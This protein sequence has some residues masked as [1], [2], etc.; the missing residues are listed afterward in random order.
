MASAD[1]E[2]GL[3][4]IIEGIHQCEKKNHAYLIHTSSAALLVD[5]DVSLGE[6]DLAIYDDIRDFDYITNLPD[7]RPYR[8]TDAVVLEAPAGNTEDRRRVRTAIIAPATVYGPGKGPGN[9]RSYQIP[10]YARIVLKNKQ[11]FTLGEGKNY[12]T[13]VHVDNLARA[14]L[15]LVEKVFRYKEVQD[16]E[17]NDENYTAGYY[18]ANDGEHVSLLSSS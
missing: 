15:L 9:K 4:T 11:A 8:L 1:N 14:Y 10:M 18:F 17:W 16:G 6:F 3:R 5:P 12:W 2:L 7:T 13:H